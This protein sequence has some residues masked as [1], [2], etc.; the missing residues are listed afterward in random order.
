MAIINHITEDQWK[1]RVIK[2]FVARSNGDKANYVV[3]KP[4]KND[5]LP[6]RIK[7]A[8][9]VIYSHRENDNFRWIIFYGC[10]THKAEI[11][12][13]DSNRL[14]HGHMETLAD[15]GTMSDLI[16]LDGPLPHLNIVYA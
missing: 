13:M 15:R 1:V 12:R 16:R 6:R 3:L 9:N 4:S 7:A 8:L 5:N 2:C 10:G 14:L 11:G